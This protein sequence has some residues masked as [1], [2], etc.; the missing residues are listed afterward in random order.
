MTEKSLNYTDPIMH[1]TRNFN[2]NYTTN[3]VG[4]YFDIYKDYE[5]N[6][7]EACKAVEVYNKQAYYIDLDFDC[8]SVA[9][10]D[11]VYIDIYGPAT[12]PEVCP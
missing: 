4:Y 9:T 2:L 12:E 11:P 1:D 7:Q 6:E 5:I 8:E 10:T 3:S